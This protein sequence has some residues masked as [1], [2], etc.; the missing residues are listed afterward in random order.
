MRGR[1]CGLSGCVSDWPVAVYPIG[2]T[3][4]S[5]SQGQ[6]L[7]LPASLPPP[8][9][10]VVAALNEHLLEASNINDPRGRAGLSVL[11]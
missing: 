10:D 8:A 5:R 2:S 11:S 6:P 4:S 9:V 1:Q 7:R 3:V